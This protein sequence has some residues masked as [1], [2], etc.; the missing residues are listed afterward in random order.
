MIKLI[1]G[2][3]KTIA[4]SDNAIKVKNVIMKIL[5]NNDI[6]FKDDDIICIEP[7]DIYY[8]PGRN[9]THIGVDISESLSNLP[10]LTDKIYA[11]YICNNEKAEC[12]ILAMEFSFQGFRPITN[13]CD[14]N[15]MIM[16]Y[17]INNKSLAL[18]EA[19]IKEWFDKST[20]R[21]NELN[22]SVKKIERN[23]E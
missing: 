19:D 7:D 5:H 4:D 9:T 2:G 14:G 15:Y 1:P 11:T 18:V 10:P 12:K 22:Q 6:E 16:I 17:Y 3:S 8:K 13:L 23:I 20:D 21:L